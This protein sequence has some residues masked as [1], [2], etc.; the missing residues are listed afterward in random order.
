[1][2]PRKER[3]KEGEKG[4]ER[5]GGRE[6]VSLKLL[7]ESNPSKFW[8]KMKQVPS[9]TD[10]ETILCLEMLFVYLIVVHAIPWI[11]VLTD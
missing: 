1:M 4:K 8:L 5:R 2:L 11:P 7:K 9:K 10:L 6:E 3:E